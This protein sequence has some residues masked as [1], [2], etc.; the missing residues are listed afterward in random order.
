MVQVWC[1]HGANDNTPSR[2]FQCAM[3]RTPYCT[4]KVTSWPGFSRIR[5]AFTSS[6]IM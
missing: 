1:L 2:R 6:T 5:S 3:L 4:L